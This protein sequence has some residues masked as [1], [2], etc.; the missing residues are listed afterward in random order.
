MTLITYKSFDFPVHLG[1]S[2]S[3][4]QKQIL[5]TRYYLHPQLFSPSHI[6]A[7]KMISQSTTPT[8]FFS[9]SPFT[10]LFKSGK[11]VIGFMRMSWSAPN[12][13]DLSTQPGLTP[14]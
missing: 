8:F 7:L 5:P 12:F 6:T 11:K 2:G 9:D 1:W 13:L 4:L 3:I 10:G 14:G